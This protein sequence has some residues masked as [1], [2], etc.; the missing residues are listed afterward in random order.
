MTPANVAVASGASYTGREPAGGPSAACSR[1]S[2]AGGV[3][4]R[5]VMMAAALAALAACSYADWSAT[6][7]SPRATYVAASNVEEEAI[8]EATGFCTYYH[9]EPAELVDRAGT[10]SRFECTHRY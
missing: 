8:A 2:Q 5:I 1:I 6:M 4:M 10:I 7:P 3:E 9:S